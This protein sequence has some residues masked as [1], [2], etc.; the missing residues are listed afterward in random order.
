M[1][2]IPSYFGCIYIYIFIFIFSS[3]VLYPWP[4]VSFCV[5]F[6]LDISVLIVLLCVSGLSLFFTGW[7]RIACIGTNDAYGAQGCAQ[8]T[9]L[10]AQQTAAST[11][12][13]SS[14]A[15]SPSS[16]SPSSSSSGGG[17]LTVAL[18]ELIGS[19]TAQTTAAQIQARA[20]ARIRE[21]RASRRMA[22]CL[23]A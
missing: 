16:S 4:Y 12:A 15:S 8:V 3:I 1:S 5:H 6:I 19:G 14:S 17:P 13:S 10:A 21:V 22:A 7:Q 2:V 20:L 9:A 23:L 18:T 11:S